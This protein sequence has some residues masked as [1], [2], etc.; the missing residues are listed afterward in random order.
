[1]D[2]ESGQDL[3]QFRD[4]PVSVAE[5]LSRY[6]E[7]GRLEVVNGQPWLDRPIREVAVNRPGLALTGFFQYFANDRVQVLGLAELT[8][9]KSLSREVERQRLAQFFEQ[10]VP[11]VVITRG[12]NAPPAMLALAQEFRVPVLRSPAITGHF[13]NQATLVLQGFNLPSVRYQACALDIMGV[14]VLLEGQPGIGKSEAALGLIERGYSMV[15]DDVVDLRRENNGALMATAPESVA[16]HM[17][18]R[19]LGIVHIPSLFGMGSITQE[20][21]MDMIVELVRQD[22]TQ[23]DDRSGLVPKFRKVLDIDLPL[24]TL[25][26]APGRDITGVIEVAVL[27]QKLKS[28]GHDAAKEF[29]ARLIHRMQR[30]SQTA[31]K[32][33]WRKTR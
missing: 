8:Y 25:P 31:P 13:I 17:E 11:C 2:S 6:R 32:V 4:K 5:F 21:R 18:I 15:S 10:G 20:K 7:H 29:D 19:G 33:R 1:M 22:P 27:N 30:K 14:G 16:Y 24:I 28:M 9:L 23:E 26:V 3:I 12:R